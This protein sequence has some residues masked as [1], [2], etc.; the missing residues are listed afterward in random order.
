MLELS[1][2]DMIALCEPLHPDIFKILSRASPE[3][4]DPLHQMRIWRGYF[5]LSKA[6]LEELKKH[7]KNFTCLFSFKDVEPYLD[8]LHKFDQKILMK[9]TRAYFILNK[10]KEK[11]KCKTIHIV[12]NPLNTWMDFLHASIVQDEPL[13]WKVTESKYLWIPIGRAFYLAPLYLCL[14]PRFKLKTASTNFERFVI[15][16]TLANYYGLKYCDVP[17]VYEALLLKR[18][19][20]IDYLNNALKH[21]YFNKAYVH[22]PNEKLA[23]SKQERIPK[24]R[25]IFRI[26][27]EDL[28]LSKYYSFILDKVTR[29]FDMYNIE[30]KW[31]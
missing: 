15:C 30:D 22:L 8:T 1:N 11:Y 7:H 6:T 5:R 24:L 17:L 2:Q 19:E 25:K 13:F 12:R 4:I 29:I 14:V 28:S 10:I 23:L 31:Y 21:P 3:Y 18:G 16:W 9:T 20:Y 26:S 27:I